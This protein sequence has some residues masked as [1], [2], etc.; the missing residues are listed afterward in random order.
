MSA[1]R[2]AR[3][4]RREDGTCQWESLPQAVL[5]MCRCSQYLTMKTFSTNEVEAGDCEIYCATHKPK[6]EE[7]AYGAGATEIQG[8]MYAQSI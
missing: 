1:L 6:M 5:Q 8:A 3:L 4:S 2:E 7:S